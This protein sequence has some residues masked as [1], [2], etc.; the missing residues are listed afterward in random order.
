M[1]SSFS[2]AGAP[3]KP[4]YVMA[5]SGLTVT[6]AEL[7][8]DSNR[9]AHFFRGIGVRKGDHIAL[10]LGTSEITFKLAWAARRSGVVYT[11][12]A[13]HLTVGEAA[14]IISDCTAKVVL[15]DAAHLELVRAAVAQ[16]PEPVPV[17]AA[18][19]EAA[20]PD[21]RKL[22]A[23]APATPIADE[24]EGTDMLYSSGTTG[25]PK[26]IIVGEGGMSAGS[27]ALVSV[28]AGLWSFDADT[29]YLSTGPLYHSA[30]LRSCTTVFRLGGTAI[31]MEKFDAEN[32][33]RLIEKYQVSHTQ[34]VPTMFVRLLRLSEHQRAAYDL[35]SHKVAVHAAAPCPRAVK[36][37]MMAW[38]GPIIYEYYGATESIGFVHIGPQEWLAHPGSVGR[39][40][41]AVAH[42]TDED[43]NELPPGS[44]GLIYFS[45]GTKFEYFNDPAK[46]EQAFSARGW[47]SVGDIGHV[48]EE[49]YLYLTD[50]HTFM[51]ISGGVNIYPQ[52]VEDLL[53]GHP[54]VFDAAVIGVPDEDMG[55]Q[56]KAVVTPV[57]MSAAGEELAREL[58]AFCRD[59]L[60]HYKCPKSV[61][62][63]AELPRRDNGKLYKRLIRDH[64]LQKEAG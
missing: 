29:V 26:G 43:G 23:Q 51:I 59:N 7:E 34:W 13:P 4:A 32:A 25:R 45:G 57:D 55:E 6:Y 5:S 2:A 27:D 10:V 50:R 9:Y 20:G 60:A 47:L 54:Q 53:L 14:Y 22:A 46:T 31:V 41:N 24:S 37:Q 30:P 1:T 58:I 21:L 64:Y 16:L 8:A 17:Y 15:T 38:W 39:P 48:D 35:S 56:V 62:F 61:D 3:D 42:I 19:T 63:W 52:E 40:M 44:D 33:L 36:E 18:G 12:L 49:G 28:F 11:I